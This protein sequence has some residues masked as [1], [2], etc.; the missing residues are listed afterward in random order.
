MK[1]I[2]A[3]LLPLI[4]ILSIGTAFA[5]DPYCGDGYVDPDEECDDGNFINRDGCSSYCLEEDMTPPTVASVDIAEDAT[6]ISTLLNQIT[7][8]FS[9]SV[10]PATINE[11]NLKLRQFTTDLDISYDLQENGTDLV[12]KINQDLYGE[13]KHSLVIN[14]VKDVVG[15]QMDEIFVRSFTTGEFIDH[16]PPTVVA[17]PPA[18]EYYIGQSVTLTPYVGDYTKSDEYIDETA[19]VY[20]TLDGSAPTTNSA[21]FE[22]FIS[23]RNDTTLKYF[24][25]DGK[26]NKSEVKTE[27]YDFDCIEKPNAKTVTPYPECIVEECI[28]GFRL[29]GNVCV[30]RLGTTDEDEYKINAVTAP[31]FGS[32]TPLNIS[33]KPAL[34]ITEEHNGIIPRPI[35]FVDLTGGTVIDFERNT[36]ITNYADG[37]SFTG[38]IK[39]PSNLYS[40]SFPINFGYTFKSIFHFEPVDG[41][42]LNFDPMYK[43]TIPFTDRYEP[44]A[45]ITVFTFD[46]LVEEYYVYDPSLVSVS[47]DGLSVT[48]LADRTNTYF[49]A[50][51]GKNYNSIVFLDTINHWA[52]N[53]IELLYRMEIVKGRSKGIFAPDDILTRAEFTK[54]A[55]KSIGEEI[56]IYEE[57]EN[58]PFVDVP[59]YAWHIPYIKRAKEMGLIKGYPDGTFRPDDPINRVEAI[60]ILMRAFQFDVY[61][62]GM[63]MDQFQDV[64]TWEWYFP[65]TNFAI[66]NRLID[67]IRLPGGRIMHEAFGP[68]RNI[69]RAEMS[70]LAVKSIELKEGM[71]QK[72]TLTTRPD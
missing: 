49:I 1:K 40:K 29:I 60:A 61:S 70:K 50:Q 22:N 16:T 24:G 48:I 57:I 58:I 12:I 71:Q 67:G 39:P 64:L 7:V 55:L 28:Y 41:G 2:C 63:R 68:G 32:D 35:H 6:G 9:E 15:N 8:T 31:L 36:K 46:P 37:T 62:T 69:T 13:A 34:Y 11:Y 19:T 23:I 30:I 65:S 59:L 72:I 18:G 4:T 47:S 27:V 38:Y 54:I 33:T 66:Q 21:V 3:L 53:Y 5:D 25:V 20:Y 42:D 10:D 14:N 51:P 17:R 52:K 26:G 56:N 43:I 44:E 45:E